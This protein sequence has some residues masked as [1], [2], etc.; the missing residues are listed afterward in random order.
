M[1]SMRSNSCTSM[2]NIPSPLAQAAIDGDVR[3]ALQLLED[4][5]D[6]NQRDARGRTPLHLAACRGAV[7][8]MR[9]LVEFGAELSAVDQQGN[10]A[11]HM[12]GHVDTTQF[13]IDCGLQSDICNSHGLTPYMLAVRRGVKKQV[14]QLLERQLSQDSRQLYMQP[15]EEKLLLAAYS[16]ER[17][18]TLEHLP[19][20]PSSSPGL[21][22]SV[23]HDWGQFVEDVG[24]KRLICL[25]VVMACLSLFVAYKVT[26]IVPL[27]DTREERIEGP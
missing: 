6:P 9:V 22:R 18:E 14:L 7:D 20:H 23:I 16:P 24:Q 19:T 12:C 17:I 13:L 26:G 8:I 10:T 11:M 27:M 2:E 15:Q 1:A 3:T 25:L 21:W 4:G 5:H